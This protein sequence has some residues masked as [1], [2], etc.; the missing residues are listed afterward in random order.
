MHDLRHPFRR[1]VRDR[2][3]SLVAAGTLALGVAVLAASPAVIDAVLLRPVV[4]DQDRVLRVWKNDAARDDMRD[5]FSYPEFKAIRDAVKHLTALAAIQYGNANAVGVTLND[6]PAAV[7]AAPVSPNFLSLVTSRR[8]VHGRWLEV[9]DDRP[10]IRATAL[11]DVRTVAERQVK[12]VCVNLRLPQRNLYMID[13]NVNLF[14]FKTDG[15]INSPNRFFRSAARWAC[16][17]RDGYSKIRP[18]YI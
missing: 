3:F 12:E 13:S 1:L 5:P 4:E 8:P 10:K 15:I 2:T 16:D 11:I 18:R 7:M 6:G 14:S 17:P 9:D